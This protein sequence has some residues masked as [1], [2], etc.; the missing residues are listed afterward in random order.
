MR[1]RC[2]FILEIQQQAMKFRNYSWGVYIDGTFAYSS[3]F[4]LKENIREIS[5]KRC[6]EILKYVKPKTFNF[7]HLNEEKNKV[8]HI[9]YIAQDFE[10]VIPKEWEG[11]ITTD[12]KGHKRLDYCKTAVITHGALQH[13]MGEYEELKDLVKSMKKEMATMKGEITR[14][15]KK[16]K[17]ESD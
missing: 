14:I 11:I 8:N 4:S 3:D 10:S 2:S 7:T 9:G 5:S 1:A 12:N 13:L 16:N 15:K 17:D 6:S